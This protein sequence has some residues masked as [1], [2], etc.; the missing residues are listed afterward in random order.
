MKETSI[1]T[2]MGSIK[3][4]R[5]VLAGYAGAI[6]TEC[7]GIVGMAGVNVKDNLVQ[8]L[9]KE[10]MTR[11]INISVHNNKIDVDFHV[12]VSY[13]VSI[14]AVCEVLIESVKYKL[15]QYTGMQVD[16]VNVYVEGVKVID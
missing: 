7:F 3:I 8:L 11:G 13:G 4:D 6:A 16:K 15:Q 12:I 5:D 10:S 2:Y 14:V 1:D 9:R